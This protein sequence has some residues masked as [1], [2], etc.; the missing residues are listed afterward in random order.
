[1]AEFAGALDCQE[2]R[3]DFGRPR[4]FIRFKACTDGD[5]DFGWSGVI[6]VR[7][8]SIVDDTLV[9]TNLDLD[10]SAPIIAARYLPTATTRGGDVPDASV[11]LGGRGSVNCVAGRETPQRLRR[12]LTITAKITR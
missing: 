7:S 12:S 10:Q 11:P 2:A 9:S 5:R 1:M 4:S 8:K 6:G 3:T